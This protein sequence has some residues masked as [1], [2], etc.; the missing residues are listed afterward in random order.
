MRYVFANNNPTYLKNLKKRKIKN[1]LMSYAYKQ[2]MIKML[3]ENHKFFAREGSIVL[4]DSGAFTVW[5]KGQSLDV[6]EYGD[7]LQELKNQYPDINF[8]FINLDVIPGKYGKKPNQ[9]DIDNSAQEGW[10]NYQY[11]KNRGLDV[12]HIFHQFEDEKWLR[13]LID[14]SDYIG[15]S[16]ANDRSIKSRVSWLKWVFGIVRTKVKTH[17]FGIT[18][19]SAIRAVPFYSADSSTWIAGVRWGQINS[20]NYNEK[21]AKFK[22]NNTDLLEIG[23][24]NGLKA[25]DEVTRLWKHRGIEWKD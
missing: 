13:R 12:M 4:I 19:K 9:K 10:N 24:E 18:A 15:I 2:G 7:F 6:K 11:L 25:Q 16:P 5:T 17:G 3:K 21:I 1:H 14:S 22:K 8:K 20:K 23:I